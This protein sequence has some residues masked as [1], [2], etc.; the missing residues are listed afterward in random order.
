MLAV[1]SMRP[2]DPKGHEHKG[3]ICPVSAVSPASRRGADT[4][5][6]P[7]S[8]WEMTEWLERE[9]FNSQQC[10]HRDRRCLLTR[11]ARYVTQT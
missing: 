9:C 10:H 5:Q 1:S 11:L 8:V 2:K 4:S 7:T 6:V 3:H